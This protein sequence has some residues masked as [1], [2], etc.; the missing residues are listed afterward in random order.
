[1]DTPV[2][3]TSVQNA[4]E[5]IR[6]LPTLPSIVLRVIEE[7]SNPDASALD[8]AR[9]IATD[10][11][12]SAALLRVVNSAYYGFYRRISTVV[13]AVVILG[14]LEVRDL[15]LAATAFDLL[16]GDSTSFDRVQL[17]RHSLAV[18]IAAER[19]SRTNKLPLQRGYYTAGLL[20]DVGKVVFN[21]LFPKL[22]AQAVE[23]AH[24]DSCPIRVVEDALFECN[25]AA[26]GAMLAEHWNLPAPVV[27]AIRNHH[28]P[29]QS[30]EDADIAHVTALADF[31]AY[32]A[33]LGE[34]SSGRAPD[35][36]E[37]PIQ[38]LGYSAESC[39]QLSE[40]IAES[41]G[42]IDALLG[43]LSP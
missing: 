15:V 26:T 43:V 36:P 2:S 31:I 25:H 28:Q 16:P 22:Y 29:E 38:V 17:W 24:A 39:K 18:A 30:D 32:E 37:T 23:K 35:P 7:A 21:L 11:S 20:H 13:D 6:T 9:H 10:Q 41:R 12:L 8:L 4:V 40:S 1:M 42:R 19:V 27:N 33:G 5:S 34:T 3:R 14:F